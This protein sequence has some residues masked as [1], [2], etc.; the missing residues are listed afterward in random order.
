MIEEYRS[1]SFLSDSGFN[2]TYMLMT[3][4]V[5]LA[6]LSIITI[7]SMVDAQNASSTAWISSFNLK[8]CNFASRGA[9]TYFILEPGYQ[10]VLENQDGQDQDSSSWLSRF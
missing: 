3:A 10:L 6:S 5:V 7:T 4:I 2:M 8:D 9:N 1:I